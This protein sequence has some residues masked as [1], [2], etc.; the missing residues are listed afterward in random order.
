MMRITC[1][2][3]ASVYRACHCHRWYH[4]R[5]R[6]SHDV[7]KVHKYAVVDIRAWNFIHQSLEV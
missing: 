2:V 5:T 3:F 4:G 7:I 6:I 1:S